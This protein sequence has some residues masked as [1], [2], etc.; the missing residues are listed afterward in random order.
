MPRLYEDLSSCWPALSVPEDYEEE[1][2][3]TGSFLEAASTRPLGAALDLGCGGGTNGSH[4]KRHFRM[5]LVDV[6][7]VMLKVSRALNPD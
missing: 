6:A 3:C 5:T 2:R 7:S 4:P 1:W